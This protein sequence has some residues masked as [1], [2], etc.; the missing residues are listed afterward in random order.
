MATTKVTT[1][2]FN[3]S[4]NWQCDHHY[5]GGK[6]YYAFKGSNMPTW[7]S[8]SV[9]FKYSLPSGA[10]VKKAQIWATLGSPYTGAAVRN[11]NGNA[12][13]YKSG[14]ES[15]ADVSISGTSGTLKATFNF[16]A[17]G[18][19]Q[20][21][22]N[23]WSTLTF[24]N[25]Y[26]WIEYEGGTPAVPPVPPDP[27]LI[28]SV[29][30]QSVCIYDETSNGVYLFDGVTKVQHNISVKLEEEPEKKKDE[31]VNNAR[32]E[33]DKVVID[34]LMSDVYSGDDPNTSGAN[35]NSAQSKA[36]NAA[37]KALIDSRNSRSTLAY[38]T[39]HWLKEQR[40]RLTLIT[41]QY[42]YV[43]M[44]VTGMTVTQDDSCPNGWQGQITLQS[45]Y[46]SKAQQ[47]NKTGTGK[48]TE[49]QPPSPSMLSG[50]IRW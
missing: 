44:I 28:Y 7:A 15:G 22:A 41:P 29:P 43:N 1:A 40:R 26:L 24:K 21:T 6:P 37:K 25:V 33:P 39:F 32:N 2:D 4:S 34:A 30:P 42:I 49:V 17:N 12:F 18:N 50:L 13:K 11:V 31:Y 9:E 46:Q 45:A 10:T 48:P 35:L 36:F 3:L 38:Q 14:S 20:D 23:H 16:K 19:K 47:Q 8:K 27:D 5:P